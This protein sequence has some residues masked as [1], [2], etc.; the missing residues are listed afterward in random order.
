MSHSQADVTTSKTVHPA[1]QVLNITRHVAP[2]KHPEHYQ[3][4]KIAVAV[5]A[6]SRPPVTRQLA[7]T[8][9]GVCIEMP[10]SVMIILVSIWTIIRYCL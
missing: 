7:A 9:R 4:A 8:I 10:T 2:G 6:K 3:L 5:P 1:N